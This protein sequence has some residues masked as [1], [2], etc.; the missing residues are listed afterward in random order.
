[1]SFGKIHESM[2]FSHP[3]FTVGSG[4]SPDLPHNVAR[5]LS[6]IGIT[7]GQE[8]HLAPKAHK[9]LCGFIISY[10]NDKER[11]MIIPHIPS[12]CDIGYQTPTSI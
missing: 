11:A 8:F 6:L 10:H 1:M 3:D 5:G 12:A 7:A 2:A 9:P 4:I